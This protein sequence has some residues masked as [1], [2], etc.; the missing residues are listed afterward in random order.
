[1]YTGIIIEDTGMGIEIQEYQKI[2]QR[3][4]RSKSVENIEGAG[5]G[6]YLS[7]MIL[8]KEKGYLTVKSQPGKGSCFTVFLQNCHK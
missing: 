7:K 2:F 5:I 4:Y 8:E 6:L 3:F 1:M